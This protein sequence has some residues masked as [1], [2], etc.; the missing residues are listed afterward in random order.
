MKGTRLFR[1]RQRQWLSPLW[2]VQGCRARHQFVLLGWG[3]CLLK[4]VHLD[5]GAR[6]CK[7]EIQIVGSRPQN[8]LDTAGPT[9]E[10]R[11]CFWLGPFSQVGGANL[12]LWWCLPVVAAREEVWMWVKSCTSSSKTAEI[13]PLQ[14]I[15]G[16]FQREGRYSSGQAGF[17]SSN[18]LR[19]VSKSF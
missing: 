4:S 2:R 3:G 7:T 11:T 10:N 16:V 1:F 8:P 9:S 13:K 17:P 5:A 12:K 6:Q 18:G 15:G 19:P 14:E